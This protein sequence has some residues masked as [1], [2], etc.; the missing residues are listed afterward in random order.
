MPH[1]RD[2]PAA[3]SLAA[4]LL[5]ACML[6]AAHAG[7]GTWTEVGDAGDRLPGQTTGGPGALTAI[8]GTLATDADVDLYCVR[9][10]DPA[11][12]TVRIPCADFEADDLWLLNDVRVGLSANDACEAGVV[13]LTGTYVPAPGVY[14]LAISGDGADANS[15]LGTIWRPATVGG[16]RA[17]DGPGASGSHRDWVG[18]PV[19]ANAHYTIALTGCVFCDASV[20]AKPTTWGAIRLLYR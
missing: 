5:A 2:A 4:V 10:L 14:F 20:P 8:Q 9:I 17:P 13:R 16:E 3:C 1:R 12:F 15:F 7:A 6:V 18:T 19:V 11:T